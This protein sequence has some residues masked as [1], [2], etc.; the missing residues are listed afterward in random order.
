[1]CQGLVSSTVAVDFHIWLINKIIKT[2]PYFSV[3]FHIFTLMNK[4]IILTHISIMFGDISRIHTHKW[5]LG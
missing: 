4:V 2:L 3:G 5:I 1:M